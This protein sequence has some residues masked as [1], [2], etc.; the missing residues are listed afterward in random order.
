MHWG[1]VRPSEV[2]TGSGVLRVGGRWGCRVCSQA[3]QGLL[4]AQSSKSREFYRFSCQEGGGAIPAPAP[5]RKQPLAL[6]GPVVLLVGLGK[7]PISSRCQGCGRQ[8][9]RCQT[10]PVGST[11]P[12]Y[13]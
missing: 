10:L 12:F 11:A 3:D 1:P 2:V 4:G 6:R 9:V 8:R 7:E 5:S 13:G